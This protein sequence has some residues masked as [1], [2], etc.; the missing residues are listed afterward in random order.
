[1]TSP[2]TVS[3]VVYSRNEADL[4][5]A[6]LPRLADFD[7]VLVCDMGS[8][9]GTVQAAQE[10]GARVVPVPDAPVVEEVRQLGLDAATS[11]WV[12]FVD[13]DELLPPGYRAT[14]QPV[15]DGP[16]DVVAVRL[17]YDNEAFGRPLWFSLQ[18]SA[19]FALL[20]RGRARYAE[21]AL[22]HV[23]PQL[24][25]RGIDAPATVPAI[26]HL[27]FRTVEQTT[28][29]VLRYAANHPDRFPV[30]DGPVALLRELVRSTV[31]S[32]VWRDGRAGF[33][34]ASL[35]TFGQLYASLL[36]QERAG[37]LAADLPAAQTRRLRVATAA[38]RGLVQA[39][40]GAARVVR[41]RR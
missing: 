1:M 6:C 31:F 9:D 40:D 11:D 30:I 3:A 41:G 26:A 35:H 10:W 32:G 28:E 15:L 20:R 13:A 34:V 23:P 8:T 19:K 16:A 36:R 7:E 25:G 12:L 21:P 18:G 27:N 17:P 22:A 33:A 24:D 4:L 14:L 38:Q 29:K 2:S 5:A 37:E 39:R